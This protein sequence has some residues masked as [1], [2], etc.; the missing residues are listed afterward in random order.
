[1]KDVAA[2]AAV[3]LQH[4]EMHAGKVY[5]LGYDAKTYPEIADILTRVVGQKF[6]YES[7]PPKE[8]LD[9]M[10]AAGADV[11]YMSCV[12]QNWIDYEARAIPRA[13]AVYDNF[14]ALTGR[15]P[16]TWV[17]FAKENAAAFQY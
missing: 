13:D 17:E 12:Y 5:H 7:R 10:L 4:P 3:V 14:F 9:E 8:F 16:R 6:T 15:N 11:A 2:V 1:V